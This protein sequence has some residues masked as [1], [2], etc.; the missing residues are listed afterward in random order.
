MILSGALYPFLATQKEKSGVFAYAMSLCASSRGGYL[1]A[2][3][4]AIFA[5]LFFYIFGFCLF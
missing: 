3:H 5:V 2:L 1:I 4:A